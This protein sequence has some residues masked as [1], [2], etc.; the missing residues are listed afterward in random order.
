MRIVC[1]ADTHGAHED[2][3]LPSGELLVCAGDVTTYGTLEE[4]AN[5]ARWLH[6]QAHPHKLLIAGNHDD[7][8]HHDATQ[9]LRILQE[10]APSITYLDN[11]SVTIEGTV[12]Y[13]APSLPP[14]TCYPDAIP[15]D[16]EILITH[17]PPLGRRDQ[18]PR[19]VHLGDERLAA[20]LAELPDLRVHIFGHVHH[21]Y[22]REDTWDTT[23]VNAAT[24]D[25]HYALANAPI[26]VDDDPIVAEVHKT[27]RHL[28][29]E[30]GENL[31]EYVRR[32]R[33][34]EA[35]YRDRVVTRPPRKPQ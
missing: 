31:D 32:L 34:T 17:I 7:C 5:C 6:D 30:A 3:R 21:S 9:A 8:L 1:I 26:V 25:E 24:C 13:G 23:F 15:A 10:D 14:F 19:G 35:E 2:L 22:G 20:R 11:A 28:W 33:E 16:T 27:R 18:T 12:F 29:S 4:F